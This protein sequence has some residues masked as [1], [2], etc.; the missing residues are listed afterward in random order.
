M[1]KTKER[2]GVGLREGST[3][4]PVRARVTTPTEKS[5]ERGER[6]L[7]DL[8]KDKVVGSSERK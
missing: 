4:R 2:R 6:R 8:A 1:T 3:P 7:P 5:Q